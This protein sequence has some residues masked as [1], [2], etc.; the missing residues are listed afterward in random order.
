MSR[1]I[2]IA[3]AFL[4]LLFVLSCINLGRQIGSHYAAWQEAIAR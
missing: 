2:L 1:K 4:A 3:A